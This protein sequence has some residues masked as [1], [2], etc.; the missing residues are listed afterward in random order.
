MGVINKRLPREPRADIYRAM[1][2]GD[3]A[4][5]EADGLLYEDVTLKARPQPQGLTYTEIF[6]S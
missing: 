3:L 6:E 1:Y 2:G 5:P 4:K